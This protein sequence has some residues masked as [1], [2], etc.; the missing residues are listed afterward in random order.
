M[1]T[2]DEPRRRPPGDATRRA[3]WRN[4][5]GGW[6]AY[7]AVGISINLLNG[8]AV[9]PL[10]AGHAVLISVSIA[11]THGLR[12]AIRRRREAG[13]PFA[14]MRGLIGLGVALISLV[15]AA[16]VIGTS[17]LLTGSQWTA[18]AVVALWWGML[19][20]TGIWTVLYIRISERR[21]HAER[22]VQSEAAIRA[23]ELHALE[24]EIGPHFLFNA[25]NSIR[26][27]VA[28][29]PG[30]AQD[31]LTRLANVLRSHLRRDREH[32]V[33]LAS[34]LEVVTDYL[35]LEGIRFEERL[36]TEI[37]VSPEIASC[38]V[39]PLLLQTLVENA[40]KHGIATLDGPGI[41]AVRGDRHG[42]QLRLTV[43]NS[44]TLSSSATSPRQLGLANVRQRLHLLYGDRASV[45]IEGG[46][47][48]VRATVTIPA[49]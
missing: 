34:E 8:A 26:A 25:L 16:T 46:R 33:T 29:D 24:R 39:P 3:Y 17:I 9:G 28:E 45:R 4:Q 20:A 47:G 11:L 42:H 48:R 2:V 49:A 12:G 14:A 19:L 10:L 44:G 23:A 31:M 5:I 32:T 18:T 6:S 7:S 21:R 40:I 1:F 38:A 43:E 27:L 41:V 13:Q 36:Q 15:Q 35:A 37:T 22:E 30:R